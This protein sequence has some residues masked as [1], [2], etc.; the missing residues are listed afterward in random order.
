MS[1][2]NEIGFFFLFCIAAKMWEATMCNEFKLWQFL[3]E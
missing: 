3:F 2:R 1:Y